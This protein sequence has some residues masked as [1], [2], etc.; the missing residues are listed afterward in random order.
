MPCRQFLPGFR[1]SATDILVLL[2]ATSASVVLALTHDWIGGVIAFVV[3]HFFLFC[4]IVRISRPLELAWAG[5]FLVLAACTVLFA[6]PGWRVTYLLLL[7]VTAIVVA[8][9]MRKPSYHGVMW[10]RINPTLREW[11]DRNPDG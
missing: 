7:A 6:I 3:C 4:N 10:D 8:I 5:A 2:V 9:E 1:L 11:W